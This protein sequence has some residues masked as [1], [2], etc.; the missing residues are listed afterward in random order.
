MQI[1]AICR[2]GACAECA[3]SDPPEQSRGFA[4]GH[5]LYLLY[6]ELCDL[7]QLR[8]VQDDAE[9]NGAA[10]HRGMAPNHQLRR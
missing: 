8:R 10:R 4:K 5:Y 9:S 1:A 7:R 3:D 2:R 6:G